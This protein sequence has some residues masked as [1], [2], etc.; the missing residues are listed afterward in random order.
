M[1]AQSVMAAFSSWNGAKIHGNKSLLSDV[2]KQRM[3]F[4]GFVVGDWNAQGQLPGCTNTDCPEAFNAG[5]DWV[6][7]SFVPSGL[8]VGTTAHIATDLVSAPF[9]WVVPLAIYLLTFV[10]TFQTKPWI[11]HSFVIDRLGVIIAPL[12]LFALSPAVVATP[13]GELSHS[14]SA[15]AIFIGCCSNMS[16]AWKSP[17]MATAMPMAN[18]R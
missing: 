8:L 18:V 10:I 13:S 6:A 2:L 16:L 3:G 14:A 5:V 4:D 11:P 17:L 9:M 7:L 12:C 15:A 1:R